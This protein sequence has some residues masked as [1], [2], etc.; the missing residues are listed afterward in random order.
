MNLHLKSIKELRGLLDGGDITAQELVQYYLDRIEKLD[1]QIHAYI[2]VNEKAMEQAEAAQKMIEAGTAGPLT[3]IV[4]G[5]KDNICTK[6]LRTTCASKMLGDFIPTYNATVSEKLE[7]QGAIFIGKLNMD[8]FAMGASTTTSHF[9]ITRNPYDT[10]RVP[11]GSS[12]GSAAAVA[13]GL[14]VA[15][16]GSDT[17]GSVRQPAA[18]CGVTGLKPTY[19]RVSRSGLVAFA[20][21]LDQIG[22]IAKSAKDCAILLDAISGADPMDMT[23]RE[24][25]PV[26][27]LMGQP[28]EGTVIGVPKEFYGGGL[29][30]EIRAAVEEAIKKYEEMGCVIKEVSMPSLPYAIPAYYLI[31]SAEASS[32]LARYDGVRYGHL[33]KEGESFDQRLI[34]TRN[35]GFGS[36]V[37]RRILLGTYALSSGYFDAYYKK[38]SLLRRRIRRE[39]EEIFK[40][41]DCIL[42]PTTPDVAFKIG[43]HSEDPTELYLADIYTVTVNI[44][45]L[46][47]VSTPCGYTKEGMPIG[48]SIVGKPFADGEILNLADAFERKFNYILND[49]CL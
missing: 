27:P 48:M 26:A 12:G 24:S 31:S 20:S 11:G 6:G 4:L 29:N 32:N 3:G 7:A 1:E 13:A 33:S 18:F 39:Y 43:S 10:E 45:G 17:G 8:E 14:C 42:T 35:E 47:A 25:E 22:P 37:K 41:C 21:S 49:F 2:T 9:G 36:E 23:S 38:A 28:I 15:S 19:G 46:P 34:A 30:P 44:A 16:L 5:I 40:T